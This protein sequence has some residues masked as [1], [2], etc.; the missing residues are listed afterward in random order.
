[1]QEL[2]AGSAISL[3]MN[4]FG[5]VGNRFSG[6]KHFRANHACR[7]DPIYILLLFILCGMTP[8]RI[9]CQRTM[10]TEPMIAPMEPN[11]CTQAAQS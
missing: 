5:S 9:V 7:L 11:A 4:G 8:L 1:L 6:T 2:E 3:G 10:L